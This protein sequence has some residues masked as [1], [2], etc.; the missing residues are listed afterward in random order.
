MT[1]FARELLD[2][3]VGLLRD[4]LRGHGFEFTVLDQ[5]SGSGGEYAFGRFVASDR[6]IEL[7][8][9][10]ALGLVTYAWAGIEVL[11]PDLLRGL[12]L[13]GEYP[14]YS[15]NPLDGFTH[16]LHDLQGPLR[17][18]VEGVDRSWFAQ[19]TERAKQPRPRLP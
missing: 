11:H 14:G 6:W 7:H 13:D 16:L 4:Y 2:Q 12:G 3:G 18:F 9:R 5:G 19:A 10:F 17:P 8:S 1:L 15:S